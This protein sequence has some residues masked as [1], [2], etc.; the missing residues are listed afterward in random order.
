MGPRER[1]STPDILIGY[2]RGVVVGLRLYVET[3]I[4][5][6]SPLP[7]PKYF[8]SFGGSD[9]RQPILHCSL[10]RSRIQI[11]RCA[12]LLSS[13]WVH[14]RTFRRA[15]LQIALQFEVAAKDDGKDDGESFQCRGQQMISPPTGSEVSLT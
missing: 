8:L 15:A 6:G 9:L 12:I 1:S 4:R 5:H 10:L 13:H 3:K 7:M 2:L 14:I 11:L